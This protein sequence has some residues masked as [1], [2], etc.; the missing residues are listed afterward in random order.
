[1]LRKMT[2]PGEKIVEEK[3]EDSEEIDTASI[4]DIGES[5]LTSDSWMLSPDIPPYSFLWES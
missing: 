1:M 2:V 4:G 3:S 5:S